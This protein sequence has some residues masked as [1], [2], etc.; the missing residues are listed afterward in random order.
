MIVMKFGGTSVKDSSAISNVVQI[1]KSRL[2]QHPIIVISAIA[3]A[4]NM[5]ESAGRLAAMGKGSEARDVLFKLF[6][7]HY[8]MVDELV[9]DKQRH[10]ALR[11]TIAASLRELEE[12]VK[13]VAIL[14]ELTPRTLDAFCCYGELLSSRIVH[15]ALI[16]QEVEAEWIDAKEFMITDENFNSAMPLMDIV[17]Q[18]LNDFVRPLL[19]RGRVPVT[20][21]FIGITNAG[22]RTTMGRESSD[23]SAS[24][25]GA[26][27]MAVD[28]QIWTDVDGIL[29]ADPL[30]VTSPK[31]IKVLSYD[32]A[33]ELSFFGAKVLHPNTM[34]PA[35]EKNIP[36]H[37]YNSQKPNLSGTFITSDSTLGKAIVKSV[38]YKRNI[39]VL[40]ISPKQRYSQYIFWEHIYGILAKYGI[41]ARMTATSEYSVSIALDTKNYADAMGHD[42]NA[43][44]TVNILNDKGIVSVVGSNIRETPEVM[45]R[46]FQSLSQYSISMMSFGASKS[47]ISLVINDADVPDAVRKIHSE[48][49]DSVTMDETFETL[50]HFAAQ[51]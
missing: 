25:I 40:T 6:D 26:A 22:R 38:A 37:I 8:A 3:Q 28:V 21:G 27:L 12:L 32:E 50:E 36:I 18:R 17:E 31:K 45:S 15:A 7:R 39:L 2:A 35:F 43:I 20:Q 10:I 11:K 13:G 4:T 29:T 44:G 19:E 47:N 51:A 5:L 34:L 30:I 41:L 49:F 16:E 33:Y 14:R 1:I 42:L 23:Y 46:I 9:K 24:I 48:F